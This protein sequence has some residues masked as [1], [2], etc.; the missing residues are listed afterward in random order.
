MFQTEAVSLNQVY[1]LEPYLRDTQLQSRQGYRVTWLR[2]CMIFNRIS[3]TLDR[4]YPNSY[5][6]I[7]IY[8]IANEVEIN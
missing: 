2:I 8:L 3:R 5:L 6:F 4:F 1:S 7:T